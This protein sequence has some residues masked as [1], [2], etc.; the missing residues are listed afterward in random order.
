MLVR[1]VCQRRW[2]RLNDGQPAGIY[3]NCSPVPRSVSVGIGLPSFVLAIMKI[4]SI[5]I[6]ACA[7]VSCS[8]GK[9]GIQEVVRPEIPADSSGPMASYMPMAQI[10]RTSGDYDC[11]VPVALDASG[12]G[13]VS[14]PAPSDLSA[15]SEPVR[16]EGGYLLDRRGVSANTAFISYTYK[17]YSALAA[18]PSLKEL[19]ASVIPGARVVEIV[20][21]P[22]TTPVAVADTVMCNRLIREGLPGCKVVYRAM[23]AQFSGM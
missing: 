22:V 12:T 16:L 15:Q 6:M 11:N 1:T 7:C 17:E 2:R 4:I 5:F 19:M 13:I 23:S 18:P 9:A 14:F 10:Y 3:R 20:S 8:G 21:L